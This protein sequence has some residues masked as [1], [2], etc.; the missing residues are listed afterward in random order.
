MSNQR[1]TI[2]EVAEHAGVSIA[3][4]S[5]FLNNPSLL[6]EDC[7]KKVELAVRELK[8]RPL[9]YARRL[10][11]G[12]L[13]SYGL[14]IPG[15]EGLF[16]SFYALEIIRG[17]GIVLDKKEIDL[18]LHIFWQKDN[19]HATLVDGAI[20]SDIIGNE[21]QLQRLI[22]ENLPV[23]VINKKIDNPQVSY[24][25]INNFKGAYDATEF[26]LH[27]GHKRIAHLA[28]NPAVQCAQERIQG[29][30]SALEKNG[31]IISNDYIKITNFSRKLA[32]EKLE[33]LFAQDLPPTAIFCCSDEVAYETLIFC[34]EKKIEVP[35]KLSII[36]F[37][38]NPNCLYGNTLL[39]TV[40]QPIK[41][42]V[43]LA[44]ETLEKVIDDT[45]DGPKKVVLD[46]EL[47]VRDT[48]QFL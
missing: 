35:R 13:N 27:H 36:G 1:I 11:G 30:K 20:F 14:I 5:R 25:A 31:I 48:V 16:Y 18:H 40:R 29:Y 44:V 43:Y 33:E 7:R 3:T 17:A 22:D 26:L 39:T 4:I 37:D 41:D 19:F 21:N 15:Y 6:K 12:K 2:K 8:Y 23:V 9:V 45:L 10:A 46:T 32:R 34:E 47:V 28:G 42:M 38:D 24:I